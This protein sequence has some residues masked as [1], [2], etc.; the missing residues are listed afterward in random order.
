M[1]VR[2]AALGRRQDGARP[3]LRET[4]RA[5]RNPNYR[6]FWFGQLVSL[7]G[8]WM[9]STALAW[10]V[11]KI[12]NSPL[13]LGTMTTIQFTPVLIF[14]LFGGV[15]ADR[16]PKQ[17]LLV[18]TQSTMLLQALVLAVLTSAHLIT[19]PLIYLLAAVQG[20]A[21]ALDNP[22]RQA[23]VA[24]LVGQEDLPNA[25]AL[26]STLFN[27][28]RLIGPALGGVAIATIGIADCF[29]LN[30]AS[31]L[32]VIGSL[33]LMKPE[34]FFSLARPPRGKMLKQVG[35][36][37]RYALTTPDIALIVLL[38]AVLGTFGYNF[39]VFLPLIAKY[40]LHMNAVGYGVLTSSVGIG[41]L[42][43][44]L[45]IA[46]SGAA[47]R[48]TLLIGGAGFSV[49]LLGVALSH[50]WQVT[51]PLL[52]ALGTFSIVFTTTANSRMQLITP[53]HL[54]GRVMS[55]YTLL[56]LGST[57]IG[58]LVIGTLAER[59]GVQLAVAEMALLCLLGV[60]AALLYLRRTRERLLTDMAVPQVAGDGAA[61][62]PQPTAAQ[63][64]ERLSNEEG[65]ERAEVQPHTTRV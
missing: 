7:I 52:V 57:P 15:I 19:L 44:A 34:R 23:L 14:V 45:A 40:T 13:A 17:R 37:L 39:S 6:L 22:A 41:S 48:R 43:A 36:G 59:Q 5:L 60:A 54:R 31:F 2:A 46:Y 8:T 58:S 38:M 1:S 47:T 29:Y 65:G 64:R 42:A 12:S 24:E 51:V 27:T 26:N 50:W 33:L 30:A 61:A 32:A 4:F 10:L 62:D 35:E 3:P 25:V 53:S 56:F 63:S 28:S 18:A 11:L 20:S 55:I 16:L 21:N 9:Q 49:L